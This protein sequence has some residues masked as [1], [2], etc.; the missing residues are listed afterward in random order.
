MRARVIVIGVFAVG[1]SMDNPAFETGAASGSE[2]GTATDSSGSA[3]GDEDNMSMGSAEAGSADGTADGTAEG[4]EAPEPLC[5]L[6]P[7]VPLQI[8]LGPGGCSG[9]DDEMYSTYRMFDSVS[10]ST[11][12]AFGCMSLEDCSDCP[13][14]MDSVA[15]P[16]S[17]GPLGLDGL[18]G[19]LEA[20]P[21]L[22]IIAHREN[23]ANP[24]A[25]GFQTVLVESVSLSGNHQ[26]VLLAS[27][28]PGVVLPTRDQMSGLAEFA[29]TLVDDE[30]CSCNE[31]PEECCNGVPTKTLAHDIGMV[32]PI[33]LG[34]HTTVVANNSVEY[35]FFALEGYAP[36]VCE[37]PT[38]AAW[39]LI[40]KP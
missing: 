1:C 23:P 27:N 4:Q 25:C 36:G 16:M 34:N 28:T 40:L 26:P 13:M 39:A 37:E 5:P 19:V 11:I 6:D 2:V 29:P 32:N 17:F 31:Y 12:Q 8:D 33:T 35:E 30:E 18:A 14:G 7:G 9:N 10:G 38:R 22:K 21:C 3:D 20:N 24:D 15:I